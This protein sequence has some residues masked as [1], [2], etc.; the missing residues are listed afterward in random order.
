VRY[1]LQ[2][3]FSSAF[4]MA[5]KQH[6]PLR[7]NRLG[8]QLLR[9]VLLLGSSVAALFSLKHMPLAEFTAIVMLTPL[10]VSVIAVVVMKEKLDGAG[11]LLLCLSFA[12]TLLIVRPG[13]A[14]SGWGAVFALICVSQAV[15][16]QL[17]SGVLGRSDHPTSTHLIT[18]WSA[19]VLF[20]LTLPWS[21]SP[22]DHPATWAWLAFMGLMGALGHWLLAHAFRHAPASTLAPFNYANLLWATLLGWAVF[23]QFPDTIAAMGMALIAAC[24]LINTRRHMR[25][26]RSA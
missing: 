8:L 1:V 17:L 2:A 22:I 19:A 7:T 13:G 21:W 4:L 25:R 23:A 15:A 10:M 18:M 11:W 26:E 6:A 16:Y 20:T 24:G 9:S 5:A 3:I 14:A 12:G